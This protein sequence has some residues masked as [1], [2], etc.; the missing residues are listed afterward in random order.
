MKVD[1]KEM[2]DGEVFLGNTYAK[3]WTESY[4]K[5][6]KSLRTIRLGQ[7]AYSIDGEKLSPDY[8]LPLFIHKSEFEKYDKIQCAR[9]SRR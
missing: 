9:L 6:F 5:H 2:R 7:Q 1:V 4:E 3:T 8:V